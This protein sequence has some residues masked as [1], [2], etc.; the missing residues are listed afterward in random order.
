MLSEGGIQVPILPKGGKIVTQLLIRSI[1][2]EMQA[3]NQK[4]STGDATHKKASLGRRRVHQEFPE[5]GL[6]AS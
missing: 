2:R 5:G 3:D 4:R 6:H 1:L